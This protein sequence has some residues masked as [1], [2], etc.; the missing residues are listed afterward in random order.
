[1][2]AQLMKDRKQCLQSLGIFLSAVCIAFALGFGMLYLIM[3]T[4][5]EPGSWFCL[6]TLFSLFALSITAILSGLGYHHEFMLSLTMGR[7]R[8]EFMLSYALRQLI[9]IGAA[10]LVTVGLYRMEM[11]LCHRLFPSFSC[12]VEFSFLGA[13]W[14]PGLVFL[15]AALSMFIG[16]MYSRFGKAA[17][18]IMYFLWLFV[19]FVLPRLI[20]ED[21]DEDSFFSVLT[22]IPGPVW[23]ILG[24]GTFA[25]MTATIW[26]FGNK[27]MVK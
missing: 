24:L 19:A 11:A 3:T 9:C 18:A 13:W 23:L 14:L 25:A 7:T 17:G 16:A 4:D 21:H 26:H 27:Q 10:L 6:G 8:R 2:F 12:E 20:P 5:T 22:A 1:M 15:L